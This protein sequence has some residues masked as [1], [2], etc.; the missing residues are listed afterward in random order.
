VAVA[1]CTGLVSRVVPR[2]LAISVAKLLLPPLRAIAVLLLALLVLE[3]LLPAAGLRP[4]SALRNRISRFRV[5]A[6]ARL[7]RA[8]DR[9]AFGTLSLALATPAATAL[10]LTHAMRNILPGILA[11]L[12]TKRGRRLFLMRLHLGDVLF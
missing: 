12:S 11:G 8:I 2:A 4:V 7:S 3:A 6:I 9:N 1:S 10:R 5:A